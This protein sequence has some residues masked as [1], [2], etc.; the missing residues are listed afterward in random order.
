MERSEIREQSPQPQD[1]GL[2][3]APSGLRSF[4]L[5]K[6]IETRSTMAHDDFERTDR[7][8]Q[9]PGGA[10]RSTAARGHVPAHRRG[11][12]D[13]LDQRVDPRPAA[14]KRAAPLQLS[15]GALL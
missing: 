5:F 14:D 4:I 7:R 8:T 2:R 10:G 12:P 15:P 11:A 1:P 13:P 6:S 9:S 3:F